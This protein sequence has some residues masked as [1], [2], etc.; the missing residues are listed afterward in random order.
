MKVANGFEY[1][2]ILDKIA[3][4]YLAME[5]D[6]IGLQ[7]GDLSK[8]VRKI[9]FTLDVLEPVVE[10]AIEKNVDMIISHHA[11][12]YRPLK[13]IDTSTGQGRMIRK[14][15]KHD[16]IVYNAH[17]NLD[18]APDGVN[19][20]LADALGLTD[21]ETIVSTYQEPFVKIAVYVPQDAEEKVRTALYNNG[22]GEV[23]NDY[24]DTSFSYEGKG[25][26]TPTG[27]ADPAIGEVNEPTIVNEIK[28]ETIIPKHLEETVIKAVRSV[29]PYEEPVIDCFDLSNLTYEQGLGRVGLLPKK[30]SMPAFIDHLKSEL[31]IE[32]VRFIGDIGKD[33]EKVAIIG[34]DGNKFIHQV[35]RTGADVYVTGDI[36]YHT[37]HDLLDLGLSTVD[38]GHHIEKIVKSVLKTKYQEEADNLKYDVEL[39]VSEANTDPFLFQ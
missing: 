6:V 11:F 17:T 31:A 3:P 34:G 12:F 5:G 25:R 37:G 28:I 38:A 19:D 9:M 21:T 4:K 32:N 35:K 33:V 16:I 18:I 8:K 15:I 1:A 26:F 29:H 22:A 20:Y 14:L 24:K 36:Y 39:I 27:D 7:V 2:A 23:G 10:E 13:K 30:T